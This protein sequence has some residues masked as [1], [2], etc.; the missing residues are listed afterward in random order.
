MCGIIG[1]VGKS[2]R[3][4]NIVIDGLKALEYRGYD[5]AG[6]AFIKNNKTQIIKEKGK[7]KNLENKIN[8]NLKT[9]LGIGHTRWATHGEPNLKNSHPHKVGK[10]TLVHNGI[11][12]NYEELKEILKNY[13]Y[14][15]IS[16]TDTEVA[17]ALID[18]LYQ[19]KND[20]VKV[21][22]KV[23][24]LIKGS[25]AFGII[26]D[27]ELDTIYATRKDSPLIVAIDDQDYYIASDIP[28]ILKYT[29]KYML[30]DD[31]D[32]V[33]MSHNNIT[34]YNNKL[35]IE[36]KKNYTF[37]GNI[38]AAEKN[39]Y[40]HFMLKEI[41]EQSTV[42]KETMF[43]Y[44]DDGI[45][46]LIDKMPDFSKY[47]EFDIVSCGSA[48]HTG[49]VAKTLI[50]NYTNIP[51]NVEIASEY[52]YK[53]LFFNKKKLIILV[54]QSGETADTLASLR[55]AKEHNMDTLAI[56]NVV[57]SS[58]A[59]EA[60]EVL[61]I[62]AGCEI[63]VATTKAYL[64]Q[65]AMFALIALKIGIS[66]QTIDENELNEIT[67]DIRRLPLLIDEILKN[68]YKN[69]A[70]K[71]FKQNDIFF[72]GRGI[73]YA[74]AMEGSLK[75]KEISYIHSEAYA[76]GELKH[77]TISLI[78]DKTPV[79]AIVTDMNIAP[80]TI[81]NIREVKARGANVILLTTIKLDDNYDFINY[82][83]VVPSIH[84]IIQS[85]LTVI[86]LQLLAYE[87][88]KLR[89]CDIDKPRNLAKSV[90]VE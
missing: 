43:P 25:Y 78:K 55:I 8:F 16:D 23:S 12:E 41:N 28:A 26:C 42:I 7:I 48:Y 47:N 61:Y 52:R 22:S 73:D 29:N 18:K 69:L 81:S 87:V 90:T 79:I 62:K 63:A 74:V 10:I 65:I 34:I 60:N 39:G 49:L 59:R 27:D 36:K 35:E 31:Y 30:L 80:K 21:L 44:L 6:I 68:D 67:Q 24:N 72:I 32:I 13:N 53:K 66:R 40:E 5:S 37:S 3:A 84:P 45:N 89:N 9:N 46:G 1:Y 75:L 58:I 57:G 64:A 56:V 2:D 76:A 38:E 11:I 86:P 4:L 51:V 88:A 54:S 82:K 19:E 33:K 70:K 83:I 85:I 50:E 17:C 71:I 15:F 20:L 77:G 14:K